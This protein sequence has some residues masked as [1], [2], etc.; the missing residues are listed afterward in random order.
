MYTH[1]IIVYIKRP[2]CD[3]L[4]YFIISMIFIDFRGPQDGPNKI[5]VLIISTR[6]LKLTIY[7]NGI[8]IYVF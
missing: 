8:I 5:I 4:T 2:D 6:S 3:I 7:V 1:P